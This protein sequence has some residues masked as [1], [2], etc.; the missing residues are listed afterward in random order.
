MCASEGVSGMIDFF[1][2][3]F[4]GLLLPKGRGI[5]ECMLLYILFQGLQRCSRRWLVQRIQPWGHSRLGTLLKLLRR[6]QVVGYHC[7]PPWTTGTAIDQ[8][9]LSS[10][11][12]GTRLSLLIPNFLVRAVLNGILL[13][14]VILHRS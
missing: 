8:N 11:Y 13:A 12:N 2:L 14:G 9:G 7:I 3:F 5:K 1:F 6:S 10:K 4:L